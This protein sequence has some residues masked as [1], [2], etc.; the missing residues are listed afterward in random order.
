[1]TATIPSLVA[2]DPGW[3]GRRVGQIA[4]SV[5][6]GVAEIAV[7]GEGRGVLLEHF[8]IGTT[9]TQ[10]TSP[11]GQ[12]AD[13]RGPEAASAVRLVH[14]H[15][16]DPDPVAGHRPAADTNRPAVEPDRGEGRPG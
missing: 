1:M 15:A 4:I 11:S 16:V 9:A 7:G 2:R 5:R 10:R 8:E 3:S 6:L 13:D 14:P 12:A